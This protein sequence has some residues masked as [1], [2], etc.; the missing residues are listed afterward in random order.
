MFFP[1][2]GHT[3]LHYYSS[4]VVVSTTCGASR[5]L[6]GVVY[7]VEGYDEGYFIPTWMAA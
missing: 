5:P 1:V 2:A 6:F 4:F 3:P 7:T